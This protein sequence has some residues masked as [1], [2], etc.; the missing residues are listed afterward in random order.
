MR[1]PPACARRHRLFRPRCDLERRRP[2]R[3]ERAISPAPAFRGS[4]PAKPDSAT[5]TS[6]SGPAARSA[7]PI[8]CF[9]RAPTPNS[10]S[11][12]GCGPISR[13]R[14]L[15]QRFVLQPARASVRRLAADGGRAECRASA[16]PLADHPAIA[17]VAQATAG[18]LPQ[19]R[20]TSG[21]GRVSPRIRI[22]RSIIREDRACAVKPRE[23]P[24]DV[25]H[26]GRMLRIA[27]AIA[28]ARGWS[29]S[30]SA[31]GAASDR[32]GSVRAIRPSCTMHSSSAIDETAS[33]TSPQGS[34]R[35]SLARIGRASV[36]PIRPRAHAADLA[37]PRFRS[38]RRSIITAIS[39]GC[40]R[41]QPHALAR[42][43]GSACRR[44]DST[45]STG[46]VEPIRAAVLTAKFNAGPCTTPRTINCA[47]ACAAPPPP[48]IAR[49]FSAAAGSGTMWLTPKPE[50]RR[51][52]ASSA[53]TAA[54]S[55]RLPASLA[56]ATLSARLDSGIAAINARSSGAEV[57]RAELNPLRRGLPP[58]PFRPDARRGEQIELKV[59][60]IFHDEDISAS[61]TL[62]DLVTGEQRVHASAGMVGSSMLAADAIPNRAAIF[63]ERNGSI[64]G[65]APGASRTATPLL[66]NDGDF[67]PMAA[68]LGLIEYR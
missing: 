45:T 57:R 1:G 10:I 33:I 49:A 25:G 34:S 27:V 26:G 19:A 65:A 64:C 43:P 32:L 18:A 58:R 2:R 22:S 16:Q 46:R 37:T 66:H 41:A 51:Q 54:A 28:L 38:S 55:R 9:G 35:N 52:S 63:H 31:W 39:S 11:P 68:H 60:H 20:I 36:R 24:R 56:R 6:S 59:V 12:S 40:R 62:C 5:S 17:E 4:S 14:T 61:R 67:H 47:T 7:C 13:R 8:S 23:W 29:I 21:G 48:I 30:S 15:P 44:R 50:K 3:R 53:G 42:I